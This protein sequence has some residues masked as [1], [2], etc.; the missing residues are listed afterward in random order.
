MN[1]LWNMG[2]DYATDCAIRTSEQKHVSQTHPQIQ[3][4][5]RPSACYERNANGSEKTPKEQ[6]SDNIGAGWHIREECRRFTRAK[7]TMIW[8]IL[9]YRR[10][11]QTHL[12]CLQTSAQVALKRQSQVRYV[13][14][15]ISRYCEM[16]LQPQ[17]CTVLHLA[18]DR[19]SP[20]K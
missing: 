8:L 3:T 16:D 1:S 6:G 18:R 14:H 9:V 13:H 20:F 4:S 7:N 19:S 17:T 10:H 11:R 2:P 12:L 5:T 15:F